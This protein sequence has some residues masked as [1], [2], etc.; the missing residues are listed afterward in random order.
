MH[1]NPTNVVGFMM[2]LRVATIVQ[3]RIASLDRYGGSDLYVI[4][5]NLVNYLQRISEGGIER[6][7]CCVAC[8]V[9]ACSGVAGVGAGAGAGAAR[10]PGRPGIGKAVRK[11]LPR[12]MSA[13][14]PQS[15]VRANTRTQHAA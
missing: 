15:H 9:A 11:G 6:V 7:A 1:L 2:N 14:T 3:L 5:E 10:P 4:V 13:H 12:K 8:C